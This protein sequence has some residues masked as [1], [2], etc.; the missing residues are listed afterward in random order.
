M[1]RIRIELDTSLAPVTISGRV[2]NELCA[3]AR[4]T[5]PEECCGLIAGNDEE[6]YRS[7]Y[8]CRNEMTLCHRKDPAQYPRDGKK[9]FLMN[10]VDYLT[11]LQEAEKV[12]EEVQAV[13]HSHVGAGVYFSEMDQ[14]FA[15]HELFPFPDVAHIVIAVWDG[16][17]A[18]FG[19]FDR[20][21]DSEGFVGRRLVAGPD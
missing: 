17:A 19:I 18:Q 14:E 6:L 15:E 20:R 5:Q 10:Q 9:A 21:V 2:L 11:A 4:E 1:G 8:R 16:P 3:H 13:Y 7:M 12:G